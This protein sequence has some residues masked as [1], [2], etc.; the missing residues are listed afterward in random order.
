MEIYAFVTGRLQ[1]SLHTRK[2][3]TFKPPPAKRN[4]QELLSAT[5]W[6]HEQRGCSTAI[7]REI[8]E[9]RAGILPLAVVAA[10]TYLLPSIIKSGN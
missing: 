7:S 8:L 2:V 6:Q 3:D 1:V 4:S 10:A 5:R 9:L